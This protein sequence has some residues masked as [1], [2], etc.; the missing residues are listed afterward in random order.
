MQRA[1]RQAGQDAVAAVGEA[2]ELCRPYV[3]GGRPVTIYIYAYIVRRSCDYSASCEA[4]ELCRPYVDGIMLRT[5]AAP[6]PSEGGGAVAHI[7]IHG[8]PPGDVCVC[9]PACVRLRARARVRVCVRAR[10]RACAHGCETAGLRVSVVCGFVCV[11]LS[12]CAF[13]CM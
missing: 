4:L 13:A 12:V 7:G 6:F 10:A 5:E 3:E 2:L 8:A 9:V 1:A 11:W